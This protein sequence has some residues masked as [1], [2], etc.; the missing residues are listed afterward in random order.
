MGSFISRIATIEIPISNLK[1]SVQWY[2]DHLEVKV[3]FQG[4]KEGHL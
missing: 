2:V 1:R 3:H 4:K